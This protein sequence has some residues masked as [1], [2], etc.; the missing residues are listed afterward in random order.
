MLYAKSFV[1]EEFKKKPY[2][3]INLIFSFFPISF[4]L[5]TFVVNLNLL[6]FCCLGI[7]YLKSKII[8][9]KY[10]FSIKII[11]LFF[12]IIFISTSLS[13]LKTLYFEGYGN[14]DFARFTKSILFF[15]FFLFLVIIYLLNKFDILHFK[16]F[17]L[18]SVFSSIFISIDIIHQYIFGFNLFGIENYGKD[19]YYGKISLGRFATR[20]SSF[21]GDEF[22]AGSYIQRFSFF[23]IFFTI[24]FLKNK[25]YL[26]FILTVVVISILGLGILFSG[27]RMPFVLF[28][29][30]L[31]IIFIFNLKIK[32]ILF[33]SL[34]TLLI[35]LKF[36]ISSNEGFHNS[37]SSFYGKARNVI[38]SPFKNSGTFILSKVEEQ[39]I[40]EDKP[41][42]Q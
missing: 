7:Y 12:L 20:N 11:F 22:I 19:A 30:G 37:Y 24:L 27:N 33:V 36:V 42:G 6:I 41:F 13:L 8:K 21:F 25:N 40:N 28:I 16:Y 3:L 15:R 1:Q 4:I 17:F 2:L 35:L 14:T 29:L 38:L 26:R 31:L 23:A 9:T 5:G 34:I 18:V 39:N 32:K 10:D